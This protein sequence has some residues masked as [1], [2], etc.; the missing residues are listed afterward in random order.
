[1][2]TRNI[3]LKIHD[4]SDIFSSL[5]PDQNMISDEVVGVEIL[6]IMGWVCVWKA[7]SIAIMQRPELLRVKRNL[8][9][10]ARAEI[11]FRIA[12]NPDSAE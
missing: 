3:K 5:D 12:D 6:S 1:M 8:E 11:V 7:T 9:R 2:K 10:M 4:E